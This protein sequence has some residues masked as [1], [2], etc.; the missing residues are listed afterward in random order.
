MKPPPCASPATRAT[1]TA[2]DTARDR[3][4]WTVVSRNAL[5]SRASSTAS[6]GTG[7]RRGCAL[8]SCACWQDSSRVSRISNL[9]PLSQKK[10]SRTGSG[11]EMET[12]KWMRLRQTQLHT[13]QERQK[14]VHLSVMTRKINMNLL[15]RRALL[16]CHIYP[17][18]LIPN[19]SLS[20]PAPSPS[21]TTARRN[22]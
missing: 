7:G 15:R 5:S 13:A 19:P 18:D 2:M 4:G 20:Y 11:G 12:V 10:Q 9:H 1:S 17:R 14:T 22:S 3:S 8:S 16:P 6:R 21:C